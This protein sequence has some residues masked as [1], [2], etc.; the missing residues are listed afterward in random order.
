VSLDGVK[1]GQGWPT[2]EDRGAWRVRGPSLWQRFR[3]WRLRWLVLVNVLIIA[4]AASVL[5]FLASGYRPLAYGEFGMRNLTY[6]GLPA[7]HGIR[8]VN[9]FGGVREDHYIPPHRGTFYLV[10]SVMN[11]GSHAVIVE[12]A[13][14][15]DSSPLASA[16]RTL[17]SRPGGGNGAIGD[18]RPSRVLHDVKLNPG[19]NIFVA[20]PVHSW[21]CAERGNWMSVPFFYVK[22]R[23]LF[24]DHIAAVP[25]GMHNDALIMHA[26]F[27]KPGQGGVFCAK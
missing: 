12:N 19:D 1:L 23:F 21:H 16:D 20:L 5:L 2:L 9:T 8:S 25:W 24:F 11:R 18:P 27:G 4:A 15:P 26:P 22:Y 10:V 14:M 7:A 3:Y 13:F 17:Y 6:P